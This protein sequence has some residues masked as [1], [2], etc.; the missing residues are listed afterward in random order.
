[1]LVTS[2]SASDKVFFSPLFIVLLFDK[3]LKN[4]VF[5]SQMSSVNL[6]L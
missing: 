2:L 5:K 4:I 6:Y 1:M 3:V